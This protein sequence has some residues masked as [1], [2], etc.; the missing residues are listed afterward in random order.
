VRSGVWPLKEY[1]DGRVVHTEIRRP[2]VPV[3]EYLVRQERFRHLF[4][5]E[6]NDAE[7][8]AIQARI[9]AYWECVD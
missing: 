8:S 9:D 1:V 2:R 7:L 4:E 3:E 6:R 5:P